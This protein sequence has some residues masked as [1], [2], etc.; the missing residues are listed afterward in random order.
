MSYL[1]KIKSWFTKPSEIEEV[2]EGVY[3]QKG[4]KLNW[5]KITVLILLPLVIIGI[6]IIIL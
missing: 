5:F 6:L 1:T 3:I 2:L 4:E